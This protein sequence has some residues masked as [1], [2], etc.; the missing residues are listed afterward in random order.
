MPPS[1]HTANTRPMNS[2][3]IAGCTGWI[4]MRKAPATPA[5]AIERAKASSLTRTGFT[6]IRRSAS[7]SCAT[8]STARPKKVRVRKS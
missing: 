8:A 5:V 6:P 2:R 4:T 7:W 3:P 1:T